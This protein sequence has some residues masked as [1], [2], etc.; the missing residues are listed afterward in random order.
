MPYLPELFL[1]HLYYG[2]RLSRGFDLRFISNSSHT[3]A[4]NTI[5]SQHVYGLRSFDEIPKVAL[6]EDE[7]D[8]SKQSRDGLC[9]SLLG[10]M[11]IRELA[12]M[13]KKNR[14]SDIEYLRR[15]ANLAWRALGLS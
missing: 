11:T 15:R 7:C 10:T 3:I 12:S 2:P 9:E 13:H 5:Q 8:M 4:F 6:E 1:E 14:N